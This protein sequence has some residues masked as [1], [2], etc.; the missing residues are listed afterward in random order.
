MLLT[1]KQFD[2]NKAEK[3]FTAEMSTLN[4]K[5]C[6]LYL[7]ASCGAGFKQLYP[8][9]CDRGVELQSSETGEI[10]LW[11]IYKIDRNGDDIAGWRL[12]PTY[13]T[14]KKCPGLQG[15]WTMLI[16]ND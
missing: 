11:A 9:A 7:D 14:L 12:R 1:T 8:D 6:V 2:I 15:G 16:I 10:S 3:R 13:D 4:Y 5:F